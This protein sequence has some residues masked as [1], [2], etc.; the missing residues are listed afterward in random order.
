[1]A[2][3]ADLTGVELHEPKGA[4]AA[5]ANT[6][7]VADGAGSGS[8]IKVTAS[9]ID[10]TSVL[11]VNTFRVTAKFADVSSASTIYI[12]LDANCTFVS[13]SIVLANA[14]TVADSILT[15]YNGT[16][17]SMGTKTIT[18]TGS[19]EG[20]RFTFTPSASATF[21]SSGFVKIATDGG[22][23]TA[24]E[25]TIILKFTLT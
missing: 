5:S 25:T 14:I 23:T 11:N 10:A 3:H 6:I 20:T 4:A 13:A 22:S 18:F 8:W 16:S 21:T 24:C 12:P 2:N 9:S 17:T 1:M 19:A 15:F 7:Y